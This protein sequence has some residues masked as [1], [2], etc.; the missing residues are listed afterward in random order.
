[1]DNPPSKI[2]A[3]ADH[4]GPNYITRFD[5]QGEPEFERTEYIRKDTEAMR[6]AGFISMDEVRGLVDE[7][8]RL[9]E[10]L[11][12]A[13]NDALEDAARVVDPAA[14]AKDGLWAK[15]LRRKAAK[16]R[17]MKEVK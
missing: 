2:I 15:N 5:C 16:I 11:A 9:K 7:V 1:M 14:N 6:D 12:T 8:D 3:W 10:Q 13:R 17:A 4:N